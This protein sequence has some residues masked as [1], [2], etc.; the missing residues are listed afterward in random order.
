HQ[1]IERNEEIQIEA[2]ETHDPN[3]SIVWMCSIKTID[4]TN[5]TAW[6]IVFLVNPT[7]FRQPCW[8]LRGAGGSG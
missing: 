4:F 5:C 7:E 8:R 3:L 2:L 1:R 6:R